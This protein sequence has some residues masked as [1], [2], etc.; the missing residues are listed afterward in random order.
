MKLL[1]TGG[2]GFI[3]SNFVRYWNKKNKEDEIIV[4]DSLTYA[5][6]RDNISELEKSDNF[7]FVEGDIVDEDL[8]GKLVSQVDTIVH[9]AAESHVDRSIMGP[10]VFL[11]TNIWGTFTL[12]EAVRGNLDVH[13][14]HVST[15]EVYGELEREAEEKFSEKTAYDPH[16]PYSA[17]KAASDHLVRAYRDTYDIKMTL[18]NCSNNYGPYQHVEKL[19]PLAITNVL[20]GKPIPVYGDGGQIRD[21]LY[22]EDHCR[23]IEAV[24]KEGELGETYMIGGMKEEVTNLQVVKMI[25]EI[26][27]KDEGRFIELV[28]DRPGHDQKYAVDWSKISNQLSWEPEKSLREGLEETIEWYRD[29]QAWWEKVKGAEF[30]EYYK[31]QYSKDNE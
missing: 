20:E 25:L 8:V 19:I 1:V 14:H 18:T 23:G 24:I 10:G 5:G 12:L 13:F 15:D 29:N 11:K 28:K 16:S 26:M 17:S 30:E 27:E 7:K 6:R 9:F 2:A 22:V 4:L 31:K 21:W 3:G